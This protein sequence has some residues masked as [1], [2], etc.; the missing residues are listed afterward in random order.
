MRFLPKKPLEKSR[1]F[2]YAKDFSVS[3]KAAFGK[4]LL[5]LIAVFAIF[6]LL[7]FDDVK[8]KQAATINAAMPMMSIYPIFGQRYYMEGICA[9]ALV[10]TTVASFLSISLLIWLA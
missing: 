9:A 2:F 5:H 3:Q 7:P 10:I 4:L 6:Y 1:G 8:L